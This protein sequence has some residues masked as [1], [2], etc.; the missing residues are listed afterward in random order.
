MIMYLIEAEF[1]S[2]DGY[3]RIPLGIFDSL[4]LA[5]HNEEKWTQFYNTKK[6][7]IFSKYNESKYRD[8]EGDII[9]MYEDEYLKLKIKFGDIYDFQDI[10]TREF[11]LNTTN[12]MT[13][14]SKNEYHDMVME[15][16]TQWDREHKL[17]IL[18]K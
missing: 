6:I 18:L 10:Y 5:K 16:S 2:Y 17:N 4:E 9:D 3:Y 7:E 12:S 1:N 14:I 11:E 8:E 13:K 15:W